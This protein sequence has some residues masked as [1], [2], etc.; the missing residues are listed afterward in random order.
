[1]MG[2]KIQRC[3]E[4][5]DEIAPLHNA[6]RRQFA[7]AVNKAVASARRAYQLDAGSYTAEAL[8]DALTVQQKLKWLNDLDDGTAK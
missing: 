4:R 8:S 5:P 6:I 3:S 2:R 7:E 1:M